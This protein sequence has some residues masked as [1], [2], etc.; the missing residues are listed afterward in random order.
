VEAVIVFGESFSI[1]PEEPS[2]PAGVAI[3]LFHCVRP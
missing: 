1:Q 2:W 3:Y